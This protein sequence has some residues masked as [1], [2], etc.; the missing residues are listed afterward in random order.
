MNKN[1]DEQFETLRQFNVE[2]KSVKE[3]VKIPILST[4][5]SSRASII[6]AV[7]PVLFTLGVV[8]AEVLKIDW[9]IT[10]AFYYWV[11]HFDEKY[12]DSSVLN[13]ILRF[14]ILGGPATIVIINLLAIL[15]VYYN[16]L[17]KEIIITVKLKLISIII[18]LF[19][20]V[21]FLYFFGYLI[22][23]NIQS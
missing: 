15:H 14:L 4:R 5:F 1:I 10:T 11:I 9:Q 2:T 18:V 12:G 23:E 20:L 7:V 22:V 8:F 6:L 13:W 16:R 19:G 3:M 17:Q 21:F